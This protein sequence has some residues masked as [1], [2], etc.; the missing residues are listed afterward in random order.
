MG[1]DPGG[2]MQDN[3][4]D[5]PVERNQQRHQIFMKIICGTDFS[6][7][8]SE[9]ANV[10]AALTAR[11]Q[12]TLSL[13]HVLD[14]SHYEL[15]SKELMDHL[16]DSRQTKLKQEAERLR[17]RGA[18]VEAQF[19]KGSPAA[20]LVKAATDSDARLIVVSSLGQI[21]PSSWFVGSVAERTAQNASIP[22]LVVRKP[23]PLEAWARGQRTL[24]VV[25]GYDFSESGDAALRWTSFL[26]EIGP[27]RMTVVYVAWPPE[28]G[29]RYGTGSDQA[30]PYY[31]A[32][33]AKL[34]QR[35]LQDKCEEVLGKTKLRFRV[36]AGLGRPDP[37]LLEV[38]ADEKADVIVVGTN[39]RRGLARLGSVSRVVLH[40]APL[41]VACIPIAAPEP[42][43]RGSSPRIQ[44]VLVTTDFSK[45]GNR[46]VPFAY[47]PLRRGGQVWLLHVAKATGRSG[48]K[49]PAIKH[50]ERNDRLSAQL[51]ALIPAEAEARGIISHL[52]V[53]EHSDVTTAICQA[54]ERLGADLIC[55]S[56]Q[57]R[58]GL[59]KTLLGSVTQ[60]VMARS[61]RP[62][63]VVRPPEAGK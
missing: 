47:A 52:E 15:P 27:C 63:L 51:H 4:T 57:G 56:S 16:C 54:A 28:A 8:A 35:D 31:P 25:I 10:A 40:H 22:T 45:P 6:T 58:S 41:N 36:A 34:L 14:T 9:A 55:M 32:D 33:I 37:Q 49:A 43:A 30:H 62:V 7:R 19:L 61:S 18:T 3:G 1:L 50:S 11:L 21:A 39:Q 53:V 38:A 5:L 23:K 44:R 42:K 12:G 29:A 59:A 20:S 60:A 46:A 13:A 2:G 26:N 17:R 24:N 48:E